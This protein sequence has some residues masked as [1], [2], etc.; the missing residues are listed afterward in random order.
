VG[1]FGDR[2]QQHGEHPAHGDTVH[3]GGSRTL[4]QLKPMRSQ[5]TA[6]TPTAEHPKPAANPNP[7]PNE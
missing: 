4:I 3:T 5:A 1:N 6:P 7:Q 2:R